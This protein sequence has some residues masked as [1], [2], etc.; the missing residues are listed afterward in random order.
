MDKHSMPILNERE[1]TH[2]DFSCVA[3][4]AQRLKVLIAAE[5]RT[6]LS[7]LSGPPGLSDVGQEALDMI[8]TKIARICCG[9]P[10]EVDHWRDIAGY[11]TLVAESL[12]PSLPTPP[13][14]AEWTWAAVFLFPHEVVA[15][16][17]LAHIHDGTGYRGHVQRIIVKQ[18]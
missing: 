13:E 8:C 18:G 7:H 16:Y 11:A 12:Q 3:N 15:R 10:N 2:G 9:N 14:A 6:Q 17:G 1:K 4:L 5:R